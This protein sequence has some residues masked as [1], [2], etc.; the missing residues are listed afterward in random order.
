MLPWLDPDDD[1]V[2]FPPIDTALED[3]NGLVAAGGSLSPTRLLNAYQQGIFPWFED[4]QPILWWSPDPRMI[5][6][7][8]EIYISTSLRKLI[9]K[10]RYHCTLDTAFNNVISAC[11]APREDQQGTWITSSMISAYQNLH[12]QG[13][14]HSVEVWLG[15]ELVGGLYGIAIGQVFFGESMFTRQNNASKVGFAFLCQ[16]LDNWGYQLIDCQVESSHLIRLGCY[17]V[18]R[19]SFAQQLETLC[20]APPKKA[21]WSQT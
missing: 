9:N 17:T 15:D 4:D 13:H 18:P 21:A 6:K 8:A 7:P 20:V 5:I 10:R 12:Q 16:Q 1:L 14:A 11:S 3:P 19:D 2:P